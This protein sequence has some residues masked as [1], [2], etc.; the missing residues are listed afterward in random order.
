MTSKRPF[1]NL[2]AIVWLV[3]LTVRQVFLILARASSRNAAELFMVAV[4]FLLLTAFGLFS[5]LLGDRK[6]WVHRFVSIML[7]LQVLIGALALFVTVMSMGH[8]ARQYPSAILF[9]CLLQ[10][11]VI[12]LFYRFAF[13]EPSRRFYQL[14]TTERGDES[15]DC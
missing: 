10:L 3:V 15:D 9:P 2:L 14:V 6:T 12:V 8:W 5:L 7:G 13:G 1:S 4:P 11:F